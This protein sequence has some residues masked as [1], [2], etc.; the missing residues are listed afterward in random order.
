MNTRTL[1]KLG[2]RASTLA[3]AQSR[4]IAGALQESNP[5]LNIELL[6]LKTRGDNDLSTPLNKVN[7]PNFFNDE[8]D[9]ALLAGEVDF[10][11]HS[12]KDLDAERP[13]G[14]VRAAMPAR[15][16]PR[17]VIIFRRDI[18][19]RLRAGNTITIG[20]SSPRRT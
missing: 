4:L 6:T 15:E 11:V 2:T 17:D 5:A 3:I 18:I 20:S 7:D 13:A 14:I 12:C 9:T 8:L 16:N 19:A 10:C 1:L